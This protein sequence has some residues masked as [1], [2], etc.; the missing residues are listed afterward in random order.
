M[1]HS[2]LDYIHVL[3]AQRHL[4]FIPEMAVYRDER[5][6][7]DA[8]PEELRGV[9]RTVAD[10]DPVSLPCS[11]EGR[12]L[13]DGSILGPGGVE[14]QL[15]VEE[16]VLDVVLDLVPP[17]V[18]WAGLTGS[19]ERLMEI[20][21]GVSVGKPPDISVLAIITPSSLSIS[22]GESSSKRPS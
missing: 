6:V 5:I 19:L 15:A 20:P 1:L 21:G 11:L 3:R 12:P 18:L 4:P 9:D 22:S 17:A 14:E 16:V 8:S 7:F 13:D 2:I 10:E